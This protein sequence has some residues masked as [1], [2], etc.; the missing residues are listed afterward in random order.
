MEQGCGTVPGARA[1]FAPALRP[2]AWWALAVVI[3]CG[4]DGR[5]VSDFTNGGPGQV[6]NISSA[7]G[8]VA[9]GG[10]GHGGASGN[11]GHGGGGG[12]RDG[13]A[14]QPRDGGASDSP[15]G[16]SDA[17]GDMVS[18]AAA[19]QQCEQQC[20]ADQGDPFFVTLYNVCYT[21][22]DCKD[23][24]FPAALP[25][26]DSYGSPTACASSGPKAG[27]HKTDLCQKVLGCL[28]SSN[29]EKLATLAEDAACW[30][31][32]TRPVDCSTNG[33]IPAGPCADVIADAL[34]ASNPTPDTK[35]MLDLISQRFQQP[36]FANMAAS[37]V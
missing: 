34:E 35:G 5:L 28:R 2:V 15:G 22:T 36:C 10:G 32:S 17:G 1:R 18:Q 30:C 20:M 14:D 11:A 29:C 13:G 9:N 23:P 24:A 25:Q 21:W 4:G 33:K 37:Y 12:P 27:A 7:D 19:C 16:G 31:G 3:G 26:C 8:G 6:I